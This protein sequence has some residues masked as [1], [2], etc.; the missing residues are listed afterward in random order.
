M[1]I[2]RECATLF[3]ANLDTHQVIQL[4][5]YLEKQMECPISADMVK[6]PYTTRCG[7]TFDYP[8]ICQSLEFKKICPVDRAAVASESLIPNKLVKEVVDQQLKTIFLAKTG[9]AF[10]YKCQISGQPLFEAIKFP[11]GHSFNQSVLKK[12]KTCLF[13]DQPFDIS[14]AIP[15]IEKRQLA[16]EHYPEY[17]RQIKIF[18]ADLDRKVVE[19]RLDDRNESIS[20]INDL[21]KCPIS[22]NLIK[23]PVINTC[24]HTFDIDSIKENTLCPF[25]QEKIS[26]SAVVKNH[27]AKNILD[28]YSNIS[29]ITA[30]IDMNV[31]NDIRGVFL[32]LKPELSNLKK[33]EKI[34]EIL[35]ILPPENKKFKSTRF[36][37]NGARLSDSEVPLSKI[38]RLNEAKSEIPSIYVSRV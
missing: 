30:K 10:A 21:I 20:K 36:F 23:N 8:S 17:L 9:D 26:A 12:F 31:R 15:D 19:L 32:L 6:T 22:K 3:S 5:K 28:G 11:C 24:G 4:S 34:A 2:S 16:H 37:V 27:M 29:E 25:D 35:G 1:S 38:E 18:N 33:I 13:D 7:H 14:D